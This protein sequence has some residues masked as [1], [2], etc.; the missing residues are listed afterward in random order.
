MICDDIKILLSGMIDGE[1]E[2]DEKKRAGDH[3]A[4]C[5]GC[6]EEYVR[7][8][9]LKEVTDDMKYFDISDKLLAGY[10]QDIYNQVERGIGWIFFSIGALT[11]LSF[12]AWEL[13]NEFFLNNKVPLLFK[14]GVA[15][16]IFGMLVL[17]ISIVRERFF[18][19]KHDR[20]DEVEI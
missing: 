15:A 4:A 10:R 3:I 9:K 17:L 7:L 1:L 14:F 16:L 19:K 5:E 2:P 12:G 8:R 20:Y 13:L 6:R 11:V 18:S